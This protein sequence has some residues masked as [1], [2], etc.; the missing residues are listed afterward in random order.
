MAITMI[1]Q[2]SGLD[3]P[4]GTADLAREAQQRTRP[5]AAHGHPNRMTNRQYT[6]A[7]DVDQGAWTGR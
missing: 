5:G 3:Y 4:L 2:L 7:D 1:P 6:S